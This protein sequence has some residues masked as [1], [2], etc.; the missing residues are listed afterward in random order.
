MENQF[1][2][3][4]TA[5]APSHEGTELNKNEANMN[6]NTNGL[7]ISDQ[8]MN[9]TVDKILENRKQE[10]E[11]LRIKLDELLQDEDKQIVRRVN[12]GATVGYVAP[13]R[14]RWIE[15]RLM[16]FTQLPILKTFVDVDTGQM[17]YDEETIELLEQR[18]PDLSRESDMALYLL[19]HPNRKFPGMLAVVQE[20]WV[21]KPDSPEWAP[22]VNGVKRASR[23]SIPLRLLDSDGRIALIDFSRAGVRAYVIDGGHRL[24]AIRAALKFVTSGSIE[25]KVGRTKQTLSV[26]AFADQYAQDLS[27]LESTLQRLPD[28]SVAIEYLPAVIKGETREEARARTRSVFVHVN[29]SMRPPTKGEQ[30]LLDEDDGFAIIARRIAMTHPIFRHNG[31]AG[32]RV[33]WKASSISATGQK[34]IPGANLRELAHDYLGVKA[35]YTKWIRPEQTIST[36]PKSVELDAGAGEINDLFNRIL[37]LNSYEKVAQGDDLDLWREFAPKGKGHL[38]MRPLGLTILVNAVA[39]LAHLPGASN[40]PPHMSLDMVFKQVERLE[41]ANGFQAVHQPTSVW[42]GITYSQDRGGMLMKNVKLAVELLKY[43]IAPDSL[44]PEGREKLRVDFAESRV[45]VQPDGTKK[46]FSAI[47]GLVGSVAEVKLPLGI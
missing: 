12:M 34:L 33:T 40:G 30:V 20:D 46:Y 29:K 27:E 32:E 7:Q 17:R 10:E 36:R 13:A 24:R 6:E 15:L 35:P 19:T 31:K 45:Q 11:Y 23:T 28:E 9:P 39:Q 16:S 25:L 5:Q 47:G 21:D 4:L 3:A 43:L 1:N 2:D 18:N 38:L 42:F 22:D 26:G 8:N 14:L 41:A 44:T 37:K